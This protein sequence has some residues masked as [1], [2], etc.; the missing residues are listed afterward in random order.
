MKSRED[1]DLVTHF[2][3]HGSQ[4]LDVRNITMAAKKSMVTIQQLV[5]QA[6]CTTPHRIFGLAVLLKI[7]EHEP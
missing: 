4:A 6:R 5:V 3:N 1:E 2:C 7:H